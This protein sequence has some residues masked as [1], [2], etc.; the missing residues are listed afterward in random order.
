M[1]F[2]DTR[3][4]QLDLPPELAR[5]IADCGFTHLTPVQ[6]RCLSKALA[7][8]DLAVQ[9]ETGS[10]KTA[11]FVLAAFAHMLRNPRPATSGS[12]PRA[13]V[14]TPTRELAVQVAQDAMNLGAHL[15]LKVQAVFGG[16]DYRKQR[17][18]LGQGVDLLVGTP[19]RLIDYLKQKVYHL[20]DVEMAI[21][22]EADRMFDM[23]FIADLRFMLR[24]MSPYNRRQS[25]LFSAT[26]ADRVV[27]LSYE[28]MNAP[29]LVE[30]DP[31]RVTAEK[32]EQ[33]LYHVSSDRKFPLMLGLLAREEWTKVLVFINTKRAGYDICDRLQHN[34][35]PCA[36]LSGDVDQEKRLKIIK[37]F[38]SGE[39][40]ILV[41]TDVASRGLHVDN[42]SHVFN[43]DL[44]QN[45]E[46]YVHR[47]GRTA[48]AGASGK[49]IT[50]ACEDYVYS[51]EEVEAYI[52][53]KIPT[54]VDL[55][56]LHTEEIPLPRSKR[57]PRPSSGLRRGGGARPGGGG[58]DGRGGGRSGAGGR[59]GGGS[60]GR[61][62]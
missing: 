12:C 22:D 33:V 24:R 21:I 52:G 47:I 17:E 4:D 53:N 34:G 18:E 46:D 28:Y 31:D 37:R 54:A 39:A 42:I 62:R 44:P 61:R 49:A 32:V 48:R 30:I 19:G 3:F 27:E 16:I 5:G 56:E 7:G 60:G 29:E 25:M 57:T 15:D 2:T 20:R 59:G 11:V 26:L 23:G 35:Y 45:A 13:I 9:A 36:L 8:Q 51:L 43:Y 55:D 40:R 50:L 10:G 1:N 14:I 6:E 41:A 38:M 58:R